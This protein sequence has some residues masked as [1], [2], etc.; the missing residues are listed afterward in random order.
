M[1]TFLMFQHLDKLYRHIFEIILCF[2]NQDLTIPIYLFII[3]GL[4]YYLFL[5]FSALFSRVQI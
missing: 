1:C 5:I 3:Y 2:I 4:M